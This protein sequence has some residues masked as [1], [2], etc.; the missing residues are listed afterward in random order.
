MSIRA[1]AA[2]GVLLC[3]AMTSFSIYLGIAEH[4]YGPRS[5]REQLETQTIV[6]RL[7]CDAA[8]TPRSTAT[9]SLAATTL[10]AGCKTVWVKV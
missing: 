9:T 5:V 6:H 3:A 1:I 10:F 7:I 8:H 4:A 2:V